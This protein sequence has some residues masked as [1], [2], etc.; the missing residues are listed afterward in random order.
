MA[1]PSGADVKIGS[2]E[3]MLAADVEDP[4]TYVA[5]NLFGD[6]NNITGTEGK[7]AANRNILFWAYDNFIQGDGLR[8]W[9]REQPARWYDGNN[10]PRIPG[11]IQSPPTRNQ[12]TI[13]TG[14]TP[15]SGF[16]TIAQGLLWYFTGR[17]GWSTSDGVTWT[18]NTQV[19]DASFADTGY[20]ITA[21]TSDGNYPFV[22]CDN[23][24]NRRIFACL[25]TTT[26]DTFVSSIAGSGNG[27]VVVQGL[28]VRDQYLYAWT[29]TALLKYD[30]TN[31]WQTT[32]ITHTNKRNRVYRPRFETV[33][34]TTYGGIASAE[35]TTVFF[36]ADDSQTTVFEYKLDPSTGQAAPRTMWNP[37]DGFSAKKIC[38]SLG[39]VYLFGDY[40]DKAAL[41]GMSLQT[42]QPLFLGY[43][44]EA[45]AAKNIRGLAP[46]YGAQILLALDDGTNSYV[47]V[48]DAEEDAFSQLDERTISADGTMTAC[49]TYRKLRLNAAFASTT[50]KLNRWAL[51]SDT[52]ASSWDWRSSAHDLDYP[53]EEKVLL[54]FH[55]VQDPTIATGTAQVFYQLD[56]DGSWTSAG[57]TSGGSKHTYIQ[58][59][60][61]SSTKKFRTLRMRIDGT[62][63]CRVFSVTA[64]AYINTRQETWR[65]KL[66]LRN[67]P[68]T[69]RRPSNRTLRSTTLGDYV[70]TIVSDGNVVTFLDGRRRY[71]KSSTDGYTT[72]T[73]LVEFPQHSIDSAQEGVAEVILRSVSPSA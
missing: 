23:G 42:K 62:N 59:S 40:Q 61:G 45:N 32:P 14:A 47:Y 49:V 21:V 37:P 11:S 57:T 36:R 64:R 72:H 8:Y 3:F 38:V 50:T 27:G 41:F 71:Q 58:V 35:N 66:D 43:V 22:A 13:T 73:V 56:E 31:D 1:L 28:A 33:V 52:P 69:K 65:L 39:I 51:D 2:R 34:G 70:R 53:H 30:H 12:A 67:E 4:Y 63:G 19:D 46:S 7:K 54:G 60:D 20:T 6:E 25:T 5:E 16:F 10:N 55:V 24:T 44:G 17:Q 15:T 48:Y 68:Q 18:E 9:D 29:R 26:C